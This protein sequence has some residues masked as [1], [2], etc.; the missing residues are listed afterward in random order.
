MRKIQL[1]FRAIQQQNSSN[2]KSDTLKPVLESQNL[3]QLIKGAISRVFSGVSAVLD[4][5]IMSECSFIHY[6]ILK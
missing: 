3:N 5:Q 6:K 2:W 1:P 4:F